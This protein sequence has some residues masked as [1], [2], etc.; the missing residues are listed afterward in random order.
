MCHRQARNTLE[1]HVKH[2]KAHNSAFVRRTFTPRR[3]SRK[4]GRSCA[5]AAPNSCVNSTAAAHSL[6]DHGRR[7]GVEKSRHSSP[8]PVITTG[9][10]TGEPHLAIRSAV[11]RRPW[12]RFARNESGRTRA[13]GDFSTALGSQCHGAGMS[14]SGRDDR[15]VMGRCGHGGRSKVR[16]PTLRW[17]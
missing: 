2:L 1:N 5:P 11:A 6:Q 14:R 4:R 13:W 12:Y 15:G 9:A 10:G 7:S 3:P 17:A 16:S 8:S